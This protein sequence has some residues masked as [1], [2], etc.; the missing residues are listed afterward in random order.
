M[1]THLL[2]LALLLLVGIDCTKDPDDTGPDDPEADA[3]ADADSDTDSDADADADADADTDADA[4]ADSDADSDA[5]TDADSDADSDANLQ[6]RIAHNPCTDPS[7]VAI[8][9]VLPSTAACDPGFDTGGTAWK[10]TLVESPAVSSGHFEAD[11]PPGDYGVVGYTGDCWGCA[12][13]TIDD[14]IVTEVEL[15]LDYTGGDWAPYL[16]LYPEQATPVSVRIFDPERT[17]DADPAYPR[18]GWQVIAHPDGQLDTLEGPRS[19]LFY[20]LALDPTAFQYSQGWCVA[21]HQ[22]QA[23]IEAAM[24]D[25]GFLPDEIDDFTTFWDPVF[26]KAAALTIYP[27]TRSLYALPIEPAPQHLLRALFVLEPGCRHVAAPRLERVDRE[28]YHA[29]EWG[30]VILPGLEQPRAPLVGRWR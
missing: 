28:G 22:A 13:F 10:D 20:E 15:F 2:P 16:Y 11:L 24:G 6:G 27:Q 23:T 4:D 14:H 21:G 1:R 12:A 18:G 29:A 19:S 7:T 5:D 3:D 26:P 25:I 30:V 8:W 17:L 9:S